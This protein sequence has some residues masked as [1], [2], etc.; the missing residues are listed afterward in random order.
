MEATTLVPGLATGIGS[1]PYRDATTAAR[2]A[3]ERTPRLPAAPQLP[4]RDPRELMVPQWLVALPEVA[5][6]PDGTIALRE[7]AAPDTEPVAEFVPEHHLGLL[8]FLD[9]ARR[10]Q[11]PPP[12]IK[13]QLAGPLTL[14]LALHDAGLRIDDAFRRGGEVVAAWIPALEELIAAKVPGTRTV[15]FLDEPG[16]VAWGGDEDG[17]LDHEGAVDLLSGA[18][19]RVSGASG[20]H[21]CGAGNVRIALEAGPRILGV[22]AGGWAVHE[23]A[24]LVRHLDADGWIAWGAVP[25]DRP[26]GE[27]VDPLWKNLASVWC[28]FAKRGADPV[29]LRSRAL[30]TPACG[31]GRH[32]ESQAEHALDL[33]N[34]LAARADDQAIAARL[35][36]GA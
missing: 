30:I 35:T 17:P 29:A 9:E 36:L 11:E 14:G 4:N 18:L 3:L 2:C 15:V 28:E 31:L 27:I 10:A 26:V 23:A 6:A 5:C 34:E 32:G 13:V 33:A 20:V 22:E 21:V 25:T 7:G 12:R 19:A 24:S 8:T 16:L 1:L